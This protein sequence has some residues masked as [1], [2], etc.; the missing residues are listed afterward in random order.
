MPS[1]SSSTGL[2]SGSLTKFNKAECKVLYLGWASSRHKN[3]EWIKSSLREK[4]LGVLV[5][6]KL[7]KTWQCVPTFQK[8]NSVLGLHQK[9]HGQKVEGG[10]SAPLVC[11]CKTASDLK[12]QSRKQ[13]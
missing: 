3:S 8:A 12:E 5:N 4:D 10:D 9:Q 7:N 13:H 2:R 6:E 11:L 1:R